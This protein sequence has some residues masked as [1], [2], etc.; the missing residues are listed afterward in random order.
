MTQEE[1]RSVSESKAGD[2]PSTDTGLPTSGRLPADESLP[3]GD[4]PL[5]ALRDI[6]FS[7]YRRQIAELRAE[8]DDLERQVTDREAL[9]GTLS[10]LLGDLIR[11]KVRDARE[12]M[13]D[14]LYPIIGQVVVRA[15]GEAIRD[16]ARTID[17][18]MR[19]TLSPR[20]L[21]RRLRARLG[22]VSSGEMALREAL[23]F[24]VSDILLIHRETGLLLWHVPSGEEGMPDTDLVS[25]MLTAIRDFSQDALGG[26]EGGQ[27][28][29]IQYGEQRILIES[30]RYAYLAV[31]VDGVEPPG[32]QAAMRE[33]VVEISHAHER[34]L[35]EYDGDPSPLTAVEA[36]LRS[37][38]TTSEPQAL[39]VPQRWAIA[40]ALAVLLVCFAGA[41]LAGRWA[42]QAAY[43]SPTP[44]V[45]AVEPPP[46]SMPT[47]TPTPTPTSTWTATVVP[48]ST[49]TATAIPTSTATATSAPT[50]TSTPT[51]A[52][53]STSTLTPTP[54]PTA[55]FVGA[56]MTGSV[57]VRQGPG[58]EYDLLGL[59]LERGRSVEVVA[60]QGNWAQV[61]WTPQDGA[62]I[63]GWVPLT[64]V[65]TLTPVPDWMITPTSVP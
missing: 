20:V 37:L 11:R 3:A 15:V 18:R 47:P 31:V 2:V 16:L 19:T 42:W 23:P 24:A 59:V 46:T 58:V 53:T 62:Q 4:A 25:G 32:F 44:A 39:S 28:E 30:A 50:M 61:R 48:T 27:L 34:V 57:Y 54:N 36:P 51:P 41:C 21:W 40:G 7:R 64:W 49:P 1:Q 29:E 65:G 9:V 52:P 13:I 6:L 45:I 33:R 8:V 35:R 43:A 63:V 10:P 17:A 55:S 22:G 60:V 12:E 14:A 5:D 38:L 26:E 56:V